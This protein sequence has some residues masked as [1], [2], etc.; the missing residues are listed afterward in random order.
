VD[1]ND[2]VYDVTIEGLHFPC[3]VYL[4]AC[5]AGLGFPITRFNLTSADVNA[6]RVQLVI[7]LDSFYLGF[8]G[9]SR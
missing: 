9:L 7:L 4:L 8:T 3:V 5:V 6:L 2:E 1:A